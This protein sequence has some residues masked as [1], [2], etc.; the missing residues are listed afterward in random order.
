[1]SEV[2]SV[3]KENNIEFKHTSE[4]DARNKVQKYDVYHFIQKVDEQ[5][6]ETDEDVYTFTHITIPQSIYDMV[7]Y[8]TRILLHRLL[9]KYYE[10]QLTRENYSKLLPKVTRHYLQ[11]DFLD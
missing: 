7:S 5:A 10:S 11:T 9:A 2:Q 8:E 1:M 4:E 3:I 6:H